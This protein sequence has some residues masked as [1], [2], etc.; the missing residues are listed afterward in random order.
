MRLTPNIIKMAMSKPK[1]A[2]VSDMT[3]NMMLL[4]KVCGFRAV[5]PIPA[6]AVIP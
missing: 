3:E 2:K 1:M 6:E 4:P 5:A